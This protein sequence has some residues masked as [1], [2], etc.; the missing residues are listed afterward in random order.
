MTLRLMQE[1]NAMLSGAYGQGTAMALRIVAET[2]RLMGAGSL[3]PV[4]SA[5]IDGALYHGDS[6]TLLSDRVVVLF[7]KVDLRASL[8][9]CGLVL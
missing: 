7:A 1:E 3:I 4:Q 8:I 5:H 9:V 6:G 2:A